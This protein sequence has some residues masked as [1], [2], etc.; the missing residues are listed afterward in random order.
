[1]DTKSPI[2]A[3]FEVV[4]GPTVIARHFGL[5]PWA[6]GKWRKQVPSDRCIE[7]EKLTDGKVTCEYLR[8]DIDWGYLRCH[9]ISPALYVPA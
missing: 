9:P 8:P 3:V 2:D 7:L 4:G 6:V 1:M 5:T